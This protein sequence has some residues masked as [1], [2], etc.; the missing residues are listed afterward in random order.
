MPVLF[1]IIIGVIALVTVGAMVVF[2]IVADRRTSRPK[3]QPDR[4]SKDA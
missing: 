3:V 4:T 1:A 2:R